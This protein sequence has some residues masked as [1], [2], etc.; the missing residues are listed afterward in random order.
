MKRRILSI[1]AT[2]AALTAPVAAAAQQSDFVQLENNTPVT[3]R[4]DRAYILLR[5]PTAENCAL[6]MLL[7]VPADEETRRFHD[8]KLQAWQKKGAKAGP[9]EDFPFQLRGMQN[10]YI[11]VAKRSFDR[12]GGV[13]AVLMDAPPG[14]YV[15]YGMGTKQSMV[16]CFCLGTVQFRAESGR[17]TDAGTFLGGLA[18]KPSRFPELAEVTNLGDTMN[19]DFPLSAGALRPFRAGDPVPTALQPLARSPARF[20]AVGAFLEP[21]AR[22]IN[23]LAPIPGVLAYRRGEVVDVQTGETIPPR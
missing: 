1:L 18:G 22:G 6:P 19:M 17:I 13:T 15:V 16:M 23:R 8:A 5:C 21:A 14:D 3:L 9:F 20:R 7:R 12:S 4:A 10:L 2:A 11:P